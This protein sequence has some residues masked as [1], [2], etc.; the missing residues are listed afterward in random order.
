MIEILSFIMAWLIYFAIY[1]ILAITL[2]LE[3]GTAGVV[4]FGKVA[5]FGLGAYIGAIVNTY[6]LLLLAGVDISKY[7]PYT[8]EGVIELGRIAV[9]NPILVL[10][11]FALSLILAFLIVGIFGYLLTYPIIRVGSGFVGFTLLSVGE[12]LRAI[13]INSEFVGG[14]QGMLGIPQPFI[15]VGNPFISDLCYMVVA[16]LF[17]ALTYWLAYRLINS[18]LGRTL[19]AIR[20]DDTAAL[21]LGKDVP[22]IKSMV[23]FISSGLSGVA[24]ALYASYISSVNPQMFGMLVT[25]NIWAMIIIGG[26][27]SPLGAIAGTFILTL[28]ERVLAFITPL[29]G[30]LPFSSD[31]LRPIIIGLIMTIVLIRYPKG[32]FPEKPIKTP[33]IDVLRKTLQ[34]G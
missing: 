21:C 26:L 9:N 3:A 30:S 8:A 22:R 10:G 2:N 18:P 31:Y 5:F 11:V 25:F 12:V 34:S 15:W 24:G 20:D 1:A 33:A 16:L 17:F 6:L 27:G 29:L 32:I 14:V 19:R 23:L 28:I 4:N 7:P 13:Y